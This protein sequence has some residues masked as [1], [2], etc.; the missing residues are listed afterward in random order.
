MVN[1]IKIVWQPLYI[2]ISF[3]VCFFGTTNGLYL[4]EQYRLKSKEYSSK[5]YSESF[6][7]FV[8]S[9]SQGGISLWSMS[10][11]GVS[12]VQLSLPDGELVHM[13]FSL[14]LLLSSLVLTCLFVKLGIFLGTKDEVYSIHKVET[15]DVYVRDGNNMTIGEMKRTK[16]R[17]SVVFRTL[18]KNLGPLIVGGF[19]FGLAVLIADYVVLSSLMMDECIIE[20]DIG[21][22]AAVVII[23]TVGGSIVCWIPFRLLALYPS[24][25]RLRLACNFL[26]AIGIC[27]ARYIVVGA[28]LKLKYVPGKTHPSPY[29]LH[30]TAN[31]DEVVLGVIIASAVFISITFLIL[32]IDSRGWFYRLTKTSR[33]VTDMVENMDKSLSI[34]E[35]NN[36]LGQ[37]NADDANILISDFRDFV[38][39]YK[40]L[41]DLNNDS[42]ERKKPSLTERRK[43]SSFTANKISLNDVE[44]SQKG[45]MNTTIPVTR[46]SNVDWSAASKFPSFQNE[47]RYS[48][49]R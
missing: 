15:L 18:F 49:P 40:T 23:G 45:F 39:G 43:R 31:V 24:F 30:A 35:K 37:L 2:V 29:P 5:L 9:L 19:T 6:L 16:N 27:G 44:R 25:E 34:L 8:W 13:K 14:D 36:A 3:I 33:L 21:V 41:L 26:S 42:P 48:I 32:I 22:V 46:Q 12:A 7:S 28:S 10:V 11:I 1:E 47:I 4:C 38:S 20:W 17:S